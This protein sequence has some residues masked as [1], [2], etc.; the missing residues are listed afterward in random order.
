MK[1]LI[2]RVKEVKI[3]GGREGKREVERDRERNIKRES[4]SL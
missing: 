2:E 3:V 1:I 4:E